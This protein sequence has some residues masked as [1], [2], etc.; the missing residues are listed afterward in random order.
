[1]RLLILLVIAIQFIA[2]LPHQQHAIIPSYQDSMHNGMKFISG[3]KFMMG[4]VENQ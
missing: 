3:G 2:F 1:M 4:C